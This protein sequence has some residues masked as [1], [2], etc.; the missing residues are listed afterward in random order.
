[1]KNLQLMPFERN[2][3][4][5]GK[6]LTTADFLAEQTYFNNKRRFNNSLLFG[7]GIVCG[8]AVYNLDDLSL[9]IES[10]VA[11]DGT[12]RE[13]VLE[14][15]SVRKLSAIE[16]FESLESEE[17]SLCIKYSEEE[18]QPV[19][20]IGASIAEGES[21]Y[22]PN[23]IRE[24][25]TLFLLD[26]HKFGNAAVIESEFLNKAC[27]YSDEYYTVNI[28]IPA[29]IPVGGKGDSGNSSNLKV[30]LTIE[31][32]RN[33][34]S[35]KTFSMDCVLQTP[36]LVAADGEHELVIKA[37]EILPEKGVPV[38]LTH[39]LKAQGQE[40]SDTMVI[41]KSNFAKIT[42]GGK[43]A[44]LPDNFILNTRLSD[45]TP[46]EL[47]EREVAKTSLESRVSGEGG[48][49]IR[50]A[51]IG[52]QRTK[53]AY[54]IDRIDEYTAKRYVKTASGEHLRREYSGWF[55]EKESNRVSQNTAETHKQ[56]SSAKFAEPT[57]ATGI[58]EIALGVNSR[59]GTVVLSDEIM[60]GLGKGNVHVSVGFEYLS[61]DKKLQNTAKNTIYG[62]ASLFGEKDLPIAYA[63]TA[64]KVMNDRG[65]F[66]IAA[67]LT[68]DTSYVVIVLRWVAVKLPTGEEQTMLKHITN[69]SISAAQPTVVLGTRES[70]FFNVLFKN[71][72]PVTLNY[73][74][75]ENDSG[76]ITADGIYTAPNKE[77]VYE[78][79]I[80]CSDMPMVRT[81]AYAVVKKK[82]LENP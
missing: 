70:H 34:D 69:K 23:R 12:G 14:N 25:A 49:Y 31:I 17:I 29:I 24:N 56:T 30:R 48:D 60:H 19:Y 8:L 80:S 77:G 53:S 44:G 58:C 54:I 55:D 42:V 4:Y 41:V 74:L 5:P 78:I 57:Y 21:E 32:I 72:E 37:E 81:Y 75:T 40:N 43:A 76:T 73:M 35:D 52:I 6:L 15:A 9:M 7:A 16:G 82:G 38:V 50:L 71:M 79:L 33:S 10:G 64:V 18:T 45:A 36:A 11:I 62:D 65:S 66:T 20:S 28:A 13:I 2:R 3:Y 39:W 47:I 27:L 67:K 26:K 46:E 63:D 68:K 51:D 22:Q 1:M 61:E 59:K